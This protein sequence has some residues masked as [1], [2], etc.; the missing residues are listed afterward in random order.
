MATLA[1]MPPGVTV[2]TGLW[3]D[4]IAAAEARLGGTPPVYQYEFSNGARFNLTYR[5]TVADTDLTSL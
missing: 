2:R 1:P 3:T 4:C 5:G